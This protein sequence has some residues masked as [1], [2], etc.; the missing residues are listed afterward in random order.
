MVSL[1]KASQDTQN[2]PQHRALSVYN[3]FRYAW[4]CEW[5]HTKLSCVEPPNFANTLLIFNL[6]SHINWQFIQ[7]YPFLLMKLYSSV[8]SFNIPTWVPSTAPIHPGNCHFSK[9]FRFISFLSS[10]DVGNFILSWTTFS[11]ITSV[12]RCIYFCRVLC[13]VPKL[14]SYPTHLWYE[15]VA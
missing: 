8:V 5:R 12:I 2:P 3:A 6:S 7:W 1:N 15:P 10:I 13:P 11:F 4:T 14:Y 9:K